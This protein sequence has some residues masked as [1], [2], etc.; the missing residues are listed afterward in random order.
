MTTTEQRLDTITR[1]DTWQLDVT[2]TSDGDITGAA[3][4]ATWRDADDGI[5]FTRRNLAAG[6][7][8]AECAITNGPSGLFS[9]YVVAANTTALSIKSGFTATLQY[10]V[11]VT[12]VTGPVRTVL[13]G[14]QV[15]RGDV[16]R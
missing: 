14:T 5:V 15:I 8:A 3:I 13:A 10:D 2:Y 12:L 9:V 16:T 1:G 4:T 6:G 7:S 11:Q